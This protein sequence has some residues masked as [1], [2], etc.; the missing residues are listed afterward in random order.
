MGI[1]IKNLGEFELVKNK[2]GVA[3]GLRFSKKLKEKEGV[4]LE[5]AIED[6]Y[7]I[8]ADMLFVFF[9]IDMAFLNSKKEVVDI[10]R[11]VKPF[12]LFVM[13]K[14]SAKYL[15]EMNSGEMSSVK[16]GDKFNF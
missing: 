3:K 9:S 6:R 12:T 16:I 8:I 1:K 5:S 4:I 11:N 10:R 2:L 13:P 14:K 7:S 15:M